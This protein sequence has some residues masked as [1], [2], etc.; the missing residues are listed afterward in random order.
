MTLD[1]VTK[2]NL[3]MGLKETYDAPA[4]EYDTCEFIDDY[5]PDMVANDWKI[6]QAEIT[7]F[8]NQMSAALESAGL[9]EIYERVNRGYGNFSNINKAST[10]TLL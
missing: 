6:I 4:P 10:A 7:Q 8:N 1:R 2:R 3:C 5:T 9:P